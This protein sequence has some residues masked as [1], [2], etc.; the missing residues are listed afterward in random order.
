MTMS[1]SLVLV[2]R[3][4]FSWCLQ[5]NGTLFCSSLIL[6]TRAIAAAA[7]NASKAYTTITDAI[8]GALNASIEA[9]GIAE[10]ASTMVSVYTAPYMT[11]VRSLG[12]NQVTGSLIEWD[13]I[14]GLYVLAI[15][16]KHMYYY[17]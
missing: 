5:S 4:C 9:V 15:V 14:L 10:E 2:S 7:L 12:Y 8:S 6:D 1:L 17:Y 3:S 11:F 13:P 16:S